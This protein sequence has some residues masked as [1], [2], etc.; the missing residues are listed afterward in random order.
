MRLSLRAQRRGGGGE[1]AG[2]QALRARTPGECL[3]R[4]EA[5]GR[6]G[7]GGLPQLDVHGEGGSTPGAKG[8]RTGETA[9]PAR[10]LPADTSRAEMGRR[11]LPP[12]QAE[13]GG[14]SLPALAFGF[15]KCSRL[16][17]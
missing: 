14:P 4:S 13:R 6:R 3:T 2:S 7:G 12:R 9:A 16:S 11:G 8:S 10:R 1:A 5:P 15:V 17:V